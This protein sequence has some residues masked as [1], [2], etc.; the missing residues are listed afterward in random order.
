MIHMMEAGIK[1][2]FSKLMIPNTSGAANAP[3]IVII[4]PIIVVITP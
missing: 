4:I 3:T 1:L 2:I